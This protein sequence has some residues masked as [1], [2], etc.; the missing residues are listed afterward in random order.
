MLTVITRAIDIPLKTRKMPFKAL[1][2]LVDLMNSAPS[3]KFASKFIA[4]ELPN[5]FYSFSSSRD[6][7]QG[8]QVI[9][10]FNFLFSEFPQFLLIITICCDFD[11]A[12]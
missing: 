10:I 6:F 8:D 9:L 2:P 3:P 11:L 12:F 7:E 4:K 5:Y 1:V